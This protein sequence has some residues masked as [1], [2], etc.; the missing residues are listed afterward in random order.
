VNNVSK[1]LFQAY[2]KVSENRWKNEDLYK[3]YREE[4][5]KFLGPNAEEL[6]FCRLVV[7]LAKKKMK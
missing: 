1:S 4:A 2:L 5:K 3:V 6:D 7:L